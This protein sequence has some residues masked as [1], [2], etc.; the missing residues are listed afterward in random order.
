[1]A[2]KALMELLFC[3]VAQLTPVRK[4][5]LSTRCFA[6]HASGKNTKRPELDALLSFVHEGDTVVVHNMEHLP[7]IWIVEK[8]KK[9]VNSVK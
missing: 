9:M 2:I 5:Q 8:S 7:A 4:K 6:D 1:L 3:P